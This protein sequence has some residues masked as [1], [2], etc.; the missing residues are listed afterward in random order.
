MHGNYDG[1]GSRF[2]GQVVATESPDP[3]R[4][5]VFG[6]LDK[7]AG[8]LRLMLINKDPE[9]PMS[10]D[11]RVDGFTPASSARRF[12]YGPDEL[13]EIITGTYTAGDGVTLPASSI[14]VLELSTDTP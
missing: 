6:A 2:A 13:T 7:P 4:L 12:T 8:V 3:E 9:S 5:S 11:L 10:V 14:T 1:Q